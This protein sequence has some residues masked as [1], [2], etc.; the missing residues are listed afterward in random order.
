MKTCKYFVFRGV[1]VISN[2][3]FKPM[4]QVHLA[5]T[6]WLKNWHK[7]SIPKFTPLFTGCQYSN[8]FLGKSKLFIPAQIAITIWF[9]KFIYGSDL[10]VM[11]FPM[12]LSAVLHWQYIISMQHSSG[13]LHWDLVL[14]MQH[15][16]F[17]DFFHISKIK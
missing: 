17:H 15:S 9:L 14:S 3:K 16:S 1:L 8:I 4:I 6:N 11:Y 13:A 10:E 7:T 5:N 12:N 2:S